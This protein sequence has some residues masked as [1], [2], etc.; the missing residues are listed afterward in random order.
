MIIKSLFILCVQVEQ[1]NWEDSMRV[2]VE[3]DIKPSEAFRIL[4]ETLHMKCV[5]EN[6]G[7]FYI[8]K[9]KDGDNQVHCKCNGQDEIYDD[10]GDLFIALSNVAVQMFPNCE[11]R[12]EDYI[13]N[14]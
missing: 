10:R 11:I 14:Y 5:L 12:N 3:F 7:Q 1:I 4:C 8:A 9:S 13:Y 2:N 6:E